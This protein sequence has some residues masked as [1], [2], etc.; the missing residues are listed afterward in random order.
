MSARSLIWR[1]YNA[2][3]SRARCSAQAKKPALAMLG[4]PNPPGST[5]TDANAATSFEP[6]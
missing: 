3:S 4:V 1:W 5:A 2:T 6:T